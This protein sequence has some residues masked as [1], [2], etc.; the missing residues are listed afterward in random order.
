LFVIIV[1]IVQQSAALAEEAEANEKRK[2]LLKSLLSRS[3]IV[4]S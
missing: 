3:K 1:A 2:S 4:S